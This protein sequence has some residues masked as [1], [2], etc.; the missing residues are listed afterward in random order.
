MEGNSPRSQL[1][2]NLIGD[3]DFIGMEEVVQN[4]IL[5]KYKLPKKRQSITSV[6]SANKKSKTKLSNEVI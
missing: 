5:N 2:N 6:P 3:G 4:L 1:L